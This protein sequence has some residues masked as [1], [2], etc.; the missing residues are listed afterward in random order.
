MCVCA[1]VCVTVACVINWQVVALLLAS[2]MAQSFQVTGALITLS[3]D[4]VCNLSKVVSSC[5]ASEIS[6]SDTLLASTNI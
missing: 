2:A 6:P 1:Y 4:R 5:T 3:A